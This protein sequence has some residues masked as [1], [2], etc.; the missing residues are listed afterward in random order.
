VPWGRGYLHQDLTC[1]QVVGLKG[2]A[3]VAGDWPIVAKL[4]ES[5]QEHSWEPRAVSTRGPEEAILA[6]CTVGVVIHVHVKNNHK[7]ITN[8]KV[9]HSGNLIQK[10]AIKRTA[11]LKKRKRDFSNQTLS[12][13]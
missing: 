7:N 5:A 8:A 9:V 13:R 11:V 3:V 12:Q 1:I 2:T 4:N 10:T 6:K